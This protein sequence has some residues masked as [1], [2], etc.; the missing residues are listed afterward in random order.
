MDTDVYEALEQIEGFN[1]LMSETLMIERLGGLARKEWIVLFLL[2]QCRQGTMA[3]CDNSIF[4]QW[5]DLVLI[6]TIL[7]FKIGGAATH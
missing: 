3:R 7:I 5:Q 1:V 6:V 2:S 4:R